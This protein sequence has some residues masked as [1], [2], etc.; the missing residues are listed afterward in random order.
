MNISVSP[1]KFFKLSYVMFSMAEEKKEK[2]YGGEVRAE[3]KKLYYY[4]EETRAEKKE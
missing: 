4:G 3:K 1:D 2:Y